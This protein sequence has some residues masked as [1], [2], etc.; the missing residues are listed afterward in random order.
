M[1]RLIKIFMLLLICLSVHLSFAQTVDTSFAGPYFLKREAYFKALPVKKNAIVFLGNSIT[2]VGE[3]TELFDA[4]NIINRGVSG[5]VTYGVIHRLPAILAQKPK[6]IFLAIGV[7]DIKRGASIEDVGISY[8]RIV[9]LIVQTSPKTKLYV[10]SILPVNEGMLAAIY[11]KIT[12]ERIHKANEEIQKITKKYGCTYVN[13]HQSA[14]K[15]KDGQLEKELSTDGLHLQPNA[16][17]IWANYLKSLKY[18]R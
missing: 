18:I 3:W 15:G 7:N 11:A 17:I 12:N 8:E 5:D 2:E 10:Q 4:K 14:L 13:L 9:K 1:K 6:K 16:Y